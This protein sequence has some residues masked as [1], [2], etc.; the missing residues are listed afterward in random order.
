MQ[1]KKSSNKMAATEE[2]KKVWRSWL[3]QKNQEKPVFSNK[4]SSPEKRP[5]QQA[6]PMR[7][8]GCIFP[9]IQGEI[10]QAV[11]IQNR[12]VRGVTK[13]EST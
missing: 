13:N 1:Y 10:Q 12:P 8:A 6:S 3:V 4:A 7:T 5:K 11:D 2:D 9:A